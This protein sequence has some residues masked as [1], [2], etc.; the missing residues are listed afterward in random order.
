[1][2]HR[3]VDD[4]RAECI[5]AN[6]ARG[7]VE[8]E[9]LGEHHH[10]A[11]GGAVDGRIGLGHEPGLAGRE[12]H[13]AAA[14]LGEHPRDRVTRRID[15]ASQIHVEHALDL[16]VTGVGEEL[17]QRD[18]GVADQDVDRAVSLHTLVDGAL[19]V[20]TAGDVGP[21]VGR[22][23]PEPFDL[24][25]ERL[26]FAVA[27]VGQHESRAFS[28]ESKGAGSADARARAGD[29]GRLSGQSRRHRGRGAERGGGRHVRGRNASG[30]AV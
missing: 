12:E 4:P 10:R 6:A 16:V 19:V 8:R 23:A 30:V 29:D 5:H 26:A 18:A 3:R 11:L 17:G 2:Q 27:Q 25:A 13:R 22:L 20:G 1:M 21:Q 9:R 15:D 7:I 28:G 14:W 24:L